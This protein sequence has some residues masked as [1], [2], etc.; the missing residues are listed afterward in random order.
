M[1]NSEI[2][3]KAAT[4]TTYGPPDV[5]TVKEAEIPVPKENEVLIKVHATTVN[6]TDCAILRARPFIMRFITGLFKPRNSIQGTDFSG[7]IESVGEKAEDWKCS[8]Q[9]RMK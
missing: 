4:Y 5:I 7:T 9:C 8:R 1:T 2:L 6:R 3:M